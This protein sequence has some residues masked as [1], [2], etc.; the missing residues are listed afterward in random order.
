MSLLQ[1]LQHLLQANLVTLC[2]PPSNP[3]VSSP[4]YNPN[5]KCVY[6]SDSPGHETD[7]CWALQFKIQDLVNNKTIKFDPPP[8]SIIIT[9]PMP[10]HGKCVNAIEDIA[11]VSSVNDLTTPLKFVKNNLLKI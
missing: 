4:K 11:F 10:N 7:H 6:H 1:A 5:T 2:D 3:N 9:A 8:T